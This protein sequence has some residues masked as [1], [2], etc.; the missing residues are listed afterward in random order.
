MQRQAACSRGALI[1]TGYGKK[2]HQM[3]IYESIKSRLHTGHPDT[4]RRILHYVQSEGKDQLY[5]HGIGVAG[6][7]TK[8]SLDK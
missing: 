4:K 3:R 8:T 6:H 1:L 5:T 2:N 7:Q